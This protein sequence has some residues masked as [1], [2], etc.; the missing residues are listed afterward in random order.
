[1][2]FVG[3]LG[4]K[5]S[6]TLYWSY[7]TT[8]SCITAQSITTGVWQI[9][10]QFLL[11][12]TLQNKGFHNAHIKMILLIVYSFLSFF[13]VT[14]WAVQK[15]L[16]E[17][18]GQNWYPVLCL[19]QGLVGGAWQRDS[20]NIRERR[21]PMSCAAPL[22]PCIRFASRVLLK[23]EYRSNCEKTLAYMLGKPTK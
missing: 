2:Y 7:S 23:F 18:F 9:E 14:F 5:Y 1:M 15:T 11:H 20:K 10:I 13:L 8:I 22:R 17:H 16:T 3:A 4:N 6:M 12:K 19:V 21:M